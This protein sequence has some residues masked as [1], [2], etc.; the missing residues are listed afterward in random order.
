ME[1]LFMDSQF[2]IYLFSSILLV[3]GY[4]LRIQHKDLRDTIKDHNQLR[5]EVQLLKQHADSKIEHLTE[6]IEDL[7]ILQKE[8]TGNI[9][10]LSSNVNEL[11]LNITKIFNKLLNPQ[12]NK[13]D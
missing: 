1:R 11:S 8:L 12:P 5:G 4:F 10:K 9:M 2:L 3:L 6:K 13:F 7:T